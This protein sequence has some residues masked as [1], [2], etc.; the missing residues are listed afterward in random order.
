MSTRLA[1][2]IL[3]MSLFL[4]AAI[5]AAP[6]PPAASLGAASFSAEPGDARSDSTA[7]A[8]SAEE[9]RALGQKLIANQHR[10]D[11]ALDEYERLERYVD[12]TSAA[13][14][15]TTEDHT[16][17]VVPTGGGTLK[18]LLKDGDKP[19]DPAE[20]RRQL[21]LWESVL[22]MMA[23][24]DSRAHTAE[25]KYAKRKR[26]RAQFVDAAGSAYVSTWA[27]RETRNGRSCDVFELRPDPNF[28]PHSMFQVALAHVSAKL[29]I[30][31]EAAQMVRGEAYVNSDISFGG[32]FLGK[33]YRGGIIS[34]E[35]SEIAP[36]VWLPT[37]YEYDFSGRKFLFP[38]EQHQTIEASHYR[39]IGSPNDAL[40]L[41]RDELAAGK[42]F[43]Y[44]P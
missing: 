16:Y 11:D 21:Q 40:A 4:A 41:A 26:E 35:Q 44:D 28:H 13:K 2:R 29:W 6:A 43:S 31:R 3:V 30:D 33:L 8:P 14:S 7:Q 32:G 23:R 37:R 38:F 39:R 20:Y 25:E 5:H 24:N 42:A 27:G 22:E 12:R 9:A 36:A 1:I 18:I 10:D 17:R 15:A 34:M 19:V